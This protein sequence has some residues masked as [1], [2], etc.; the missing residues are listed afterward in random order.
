M[1]IFSRLH[2][3]MISPSGLDEREAR[4]KSCAVSCVRIK[5]KISCFVGPGNRML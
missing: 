1:Y 3:R 4:P 5:T 2:N